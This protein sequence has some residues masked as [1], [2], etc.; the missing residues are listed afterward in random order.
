MFT[1]SQVCGIMATDNGWD[2]PPIQM[3]V[4]MGIM[5]IWFA[6]LFIVGPF[7]MAYAMS[8]LMSD[9]ELKK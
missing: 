4:V 2:K 8:K 1:H 3:E 6:V 7:A 9:G 5:V